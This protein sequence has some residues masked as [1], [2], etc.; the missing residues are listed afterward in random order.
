M[1]KCKDKKKCKVF[2]G[3]HIKVHLLQLLLGTQ[4]VC[5]STFLLTAIGGSWMKTSI[6]FTAYHL[7]TVVL[8]GQETK[9]RFDDTTTQTQHQVQCRF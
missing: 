1:I 7:V 6:A 2:L 8:L 9:S 5:V 4:V 3:V